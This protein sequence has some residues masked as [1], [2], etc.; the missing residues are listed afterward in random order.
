MARRSPLVFEA[1]VDLPLEVAAGKA[2]AGVVETSFAAAVGKRPEAEE[3]V[4]VGSLHLSKPPAFGPPEVVEGERSG[5]TNGSAH[6]SG[7]V[8]AEIGW[9]K[10]EGQEPK[11]KEATSEKVMV[12]V[13]AVAA[14]VVFHVEQASRWLA[15]PSWASC[16]SHPGPFPRS[17]LRSPSAC[18]KSW[19]PGGRIARGK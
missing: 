2:A 18:R 19:E 8:E 14:V 12:G 3:Q 10:P 7:D 9:K 5:R 13:V 15:D 1:T 17:C 4:A 6:A 11:L 16:S